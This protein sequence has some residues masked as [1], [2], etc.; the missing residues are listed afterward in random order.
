MAVN[1]NQTLSISVMSGKGGVGKTNIAL[2]MA[3][4]L[5][6]IGGRLLLLDCDLG[7]ANLDVLLGISPEKNLQDLLIPDTGIREVITP[8]SPGFDF[9]PAASGVT[10]LVD[11]DEDTQSLLFAKLRSSFSRYE[12]LV[13]DL[14]AGINRTVLSFAAITRMRVVVVTPEP[15]SLTDSYALMK[16]LRT[17]YGVDEF[18]IVVN[19]VEDEEEGQLTFD[20]LSA[21]CD[22]FLGIQP[23]LLGMVHRDKALSEAVLRQIPLIKYDPQ[24]RACQNIHAIAQKIRRY[25]ESNLN[26]L[27]DVPA[28]KAF[29]V[30][31][32]DNP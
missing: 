24:S 32:P 10:E 29:P 16:V 17:E 15:T 23:R 2:N 30:G 1:K 4:M 22:K 14:G 31:F 18:R 7:L 11:M 28:L 5:H 3:Y 20:R 25:R 19:M 27:S 8:V 21:A 26:L 13:L 6:D 12:Y 9:L